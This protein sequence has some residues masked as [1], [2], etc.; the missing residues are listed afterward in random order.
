[1]SPGEITSAHRMALRKRASAEMII[2][3]ALNLRSLCFFQIA[4]ACILVVLMHSGALADRLHLANGSVIEADEVWEDAQGV[5]FRRNGITELVERNRVR[6]I[7]R[8]KQGVTRLQKPKQDTDRLANLAQSDRLWIH[9]TGGAQIEVDEVSEEGNGFWYRRG[10]V[11]IFLERA[12]VHWIEKRESTLDG[13]ATPSRGWTTGNTYLDQLIRRNGHQFDVDPY[14]IFCVIEQ[15]SRFRVRAV[16]PKGARGLMQLMPGTAARFGVKRVFDP[17]EN[18]RGGTRYLRELLDMFDGRLELALASYNAGEGAV[19]K[20]GRR[21]PPYSETQNYVKRINS[22]YGR[23]SAPA[24]PTKEG[25]E[26]E[27]P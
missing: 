19:L 23:S 6:R 7:E 26:K 21:I 27:N 13:S 1:M 11:S 22:R 2:V 5:W 16:S 14:L 15:E 20:Y 10:S 25:S 12:R 18:I 4:V 24:Q 8:K 9:L 3:R 17:A